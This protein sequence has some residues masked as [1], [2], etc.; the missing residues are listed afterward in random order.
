MTRFH[1]SCGPRSGPV[2]S[3]DPI[4]ASQSSFDNKEKECEVNNQHSL[5]SSSQDLCAID[6]L[7]KCLQIDQKRVWRNKGQERG[8]GQAKG[9]DGFSQIFPTKH[10][11]PDDFKQQKRIASLF[12]SPQKSEIKVLAGLCSPKSL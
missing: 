6:L 7:G 12:W 8:G 11:R 1:S 2:S 3:F 4:S 10:P 5:L 9:A